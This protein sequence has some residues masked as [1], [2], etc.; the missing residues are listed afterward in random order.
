MSVFARTFGVLCTGADED[1]LARV[2]HPNEN[3][4]GR[5]RLQN[6]QVQKYDIGD[7]PQR[8]SSSRCR[9]DNKTRSIFKENLVGRVA[10]AFQRAQGRHVVHRASSPPTALPAVLYRKGKA[11]P[12][13]KAGNHGLGANKRKK[14]HRLGRQARIRRKVCREFVVLRRYEDRRDNGCE[15]FERS[16]V[17]T[18]S[19]D[20]FLDEERAHGKANCI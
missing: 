14:Q 1:G 3:R 6:L 9:K 12:H 19:Q 18:D 15:S 11:P 17:K 20:S 7:R 2:V 10:A 16:N 5:T 8:Q 13:G 4:K